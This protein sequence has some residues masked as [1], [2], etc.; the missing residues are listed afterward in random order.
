[1]GRWGTGSSAF[2]GNTDFSRIPA[3]SK[4]SQGRRASSLCLLTQISR[5]PVI[6]AYSVFPQA[7]ECLNLVSTY[8]P[9]SWPSQDQLNLTGPCWFCDSDL[10]TIDAW[11]EW[12]DGKESRLPVLPRKVVCA[13][14]WVHICIKMHARVCACIW[15]SEDNIGG[16]SSGAI[17]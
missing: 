4:D 13:C 5:L 8:F 11:L 16:H 1:M 10:A 14:V 15:R 9:F 17:T 12:C 3:R 6:L 7:Y 2:W